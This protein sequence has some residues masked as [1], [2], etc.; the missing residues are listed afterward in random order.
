MSK[1]IIVVGAG[2]AG[3]MAAIS[4]ARSG[5]EVT[6]LE[7]MERPGKKLLLT[8]NGRCN[9][10][11]TDEK[12]P[13][14]Y[15]GTG[16]ELAASVI[17]TFDASAVCRFFEE[18]GLPAWSKNGYIYPYTAQSSSVLE[19]LLAEL[20]RLKVKLKLS[21]K[22]ESLFKENEKWK[23]NTATWCYTA[24]A[25]I[26]CCGSK[27]LPATGSDGSGYAL[28]ASLGHSVI[29]AAPALTPLICKDSCLLQLAGVRCRAELE[30]RQ[31]TECGGN[32]L[33]KKEI[34]ELQWTKYGVSG[35]VVFQLSR[36]VSALPSPDNLYLSIDLL[37]DL[38]TEKLENM[39][40]QRAGMLPGEKVSVSLSGMLHEK[41]IPVILKKAAVQP[42]ATCQQLTQQ[43]IST[44]I[45]RIKNFNLKIAGTKSF[46]VCQVCAGGVD[47]R[48]ISEH[49]ESLKHSGLFFAGEIL[50]VDGPCGGYNLQWAW[51]SGYA[52][53]TA[54]AAL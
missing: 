50:D 9:L 15:Y 30:L 8:G 25:V 36:F 45:N 29:E 22:T 52:A 31:Q 3:M 10:T 41:L 42:K 19:V 49:M 21:E 20:R 23:V 24:D 35:I 13:A 43:Q 54:A 37:P 7:G 28:A 38:E 1:K 40:L 44:I 26:L 11:N 14:A 6:V 18:L 51:S 39:L 46:D 32:K 47:C 5:A 53:G 4:A 2:A 33:L 12:L 16:A 48:E 27:A 17:P 34:G